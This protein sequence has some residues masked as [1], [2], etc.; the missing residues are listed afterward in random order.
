MTIETHQDLTTYLANSTN[1]EL[2]AA[3][4]ESEKHNTPAWNTVASAIIEE[5]AKNRTAIRDW[6]GARNTDLYAKFQAPLE[7][8]A[9]ARG[10]ALA[11]VE[12]HPM[13]ST[14]SATP[15]SRKMRLAVRALEG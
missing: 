6:I 2:A 8:A 15:Y 3:M 13:M 5:I 1:N 10:E 14:W 7:D 9:E 12:T 4:A 11:T